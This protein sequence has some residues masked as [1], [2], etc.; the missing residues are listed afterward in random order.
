MEKYAALGEIAGIK[1]RCCEK[2]QAININEKNRLFSEMTMAQNKKKQIKELIT[3]ESQGME[4]IKKTGAS[5]MEDEESRSVAIKA[6]FEV[7]MQEIKDE[8]PVDEELLVQLEDVNKDLRASAAKAGECV[9]ETEEDYK[10]KI[11]SLK[12]HCEEKD[13]LL[14]EKVSTL[15]AP[16]EEVDSLKKS[17]KD[18]EDK[19]RQQKIRAGYL[20]KRLKECKSILEQTKSSLDN[21]INE[22]KS[23]V[24]K[25]KTQVEKLNVHRN[26]FD[27]YND[28]ILEIVNENSELEIQIKEKQRTLNG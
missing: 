17:T 5:I 6:K 1:S 8:N 15:K 12:A 22:T 2:D 23:I 24:A 9:K 19:S 16:L 26:A 4:N 3:Q 25:A 13:K 28:G 14:N 11:Q 20:E 7:A 10:S 18:N 21:F 27:K